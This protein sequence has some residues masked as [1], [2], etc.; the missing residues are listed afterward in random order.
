MNDLRGI[1][2]IPAIIMLH[3][4]ITIL[5]SSPMGNNMLIKYKHGGRTQYSTNTVKM[6]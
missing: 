2:I 3:G 1:V 6:S 5:Y 4:N